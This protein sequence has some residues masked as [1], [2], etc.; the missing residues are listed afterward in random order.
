MAEEHSDWTEEDGFQ[1]IMHPAYEKT[2]KRKIRDDEDEAA[3]K[4]AYKARVQKA[5]EK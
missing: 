3:W 5:S 2:Y 1:W 4:R